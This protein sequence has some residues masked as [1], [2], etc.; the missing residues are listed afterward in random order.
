MT[1]EIIA[2]GS[3]ANAV[4]IEKTLVDCGVPFAKLQERLYDVKVLLIT[5]VHSDHLK[6]ATFQKIRKSHPR[7]TVI[8]NHEVHQTVGVD[9]ISNPGYEIK[10]GGTIYLPFEAPHDV[11]CHGYVWEVKGQRIIYATD[12]W[13]TE[14]APEGP[15]DWIFME[16]NHDETKVQEVMN[17]SHNGYDAWRSAKRHLSRQQAKE[18][19][20]VNRRGK[21][22]QWIELHKSERFY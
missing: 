19:Y 6:K 21:E 11:E 7:I 12:L 14:Y 4:I 15:Y 13:S 20:Y 10:A 3:K 17:R 9:V 2:S 8:G 22:S 5:H 16:S 18:F 1:F